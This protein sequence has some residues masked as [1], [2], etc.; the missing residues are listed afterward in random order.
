MNILNLAWLLISTMPALG[1]QGRITKEASIGYMMNP[2]LK[3]NEPGMM[4][5]TCDPAFRRLTQKD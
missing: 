2:Y 4:T 1:R 3:T 5:I